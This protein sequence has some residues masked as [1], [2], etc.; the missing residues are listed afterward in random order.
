MGLLFFCPP[1]ETKHV[2]TQGFSGCRFVSLVNSHY[3]P[4]RCSIKF[5]KKNEIF[6]RL[7]EFTKQIHSLEIT[8]SPGATHPSNNRELCSGR[9][10]SKSREL[11]VAYVTEVKVE[12]FVQRVSTCLHLP[13]L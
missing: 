11:Y 2:V 12:S 4:L 8:L 5:R 9:D 10:G 1:S 7:N 6:K 13:A 3:C